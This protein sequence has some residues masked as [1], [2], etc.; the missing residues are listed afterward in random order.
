MVKRLSI[1]KFEEYKRGSNS[2][3]DDCL[4]RIKDILKRYEPTF[5]QINVDNKIMTEKTNKIEITMVIF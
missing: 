4:T 5:E 1:E 3:L 2:K